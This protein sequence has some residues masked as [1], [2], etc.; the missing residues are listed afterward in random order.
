MVLDGGANVFGSYHGPD[1]EDLFQRIPATFFKSMGFIAVASLLGGALTG[2]TLP[3][4]D[5]I[6]TRW[7]GAVMGGMVLA[8]DI[9]K[10]MPGDVFREEVD[11]YTRDLRDT[12]DPIPGT[13]QVRLP[14]HIEAER[15]AM[16]RREGIQFGEQEQQ[17]MQALHERY[18]I[19]LPW[20]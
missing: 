7:P 1:F 8:I 17:T 20:N 14:G 16:H 4:G 9:N 12:H 6:E 11:R 13:D 18:H 5:A 2:Y 19:P 3:E 10:M 15:T